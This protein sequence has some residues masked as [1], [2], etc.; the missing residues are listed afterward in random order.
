MS[1]KKYN[2]LETRAWIN[3]A[4]YG[5]WFNRLYAVA[6]SVFKWNGLPETVDPVFL[7]KVLFWRGFGVY[8]ADE[9][10]GQLFLPMATASDLDV[11]GYPKDRQAVSYNYTSRF[12]SDADS[13]LVYDNYAAYSMAVMAKMYAVR[14]YDLDVAIDVNC[15]AQK[16]PIL[17]T[18]DQKELLSLQNIY[19]QYD[20]NQPVIYATKAFNPEGV[21]VLKTDAPFNA[22]GLQQLKRQL[23]EEALVFL[24]VEANTN[25]KA[26]RLVSSEIDSNLGATE[27]FRLNRLKRR[28]QAAERISKMFGVNVSVEFD[29]SLRLS[30]L[31]NGV[32]D[33]GA[34]Y[35]DGE[36]PLRKPNGDAS[37]TPENGNS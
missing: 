20:G 25:E 21:A 9:I 23:F 12:L 15:K 27:A 24:G 18:C 10:L 29:S 13:V 35:D 28:Q 2:S 32:D 16:T 5:A 11:Y 26:E 19:M 8:F 37:P 14:L 4:T 33:N 31:M 3:N 36:N 30:V 7:E 1:R 22:P 34:V 6:I 17:V